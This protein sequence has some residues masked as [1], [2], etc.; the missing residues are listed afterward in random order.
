MTAT[1]EAERRA[2][3]VIRRWADQIAAARR[4]GDHLR[5]SQY[6]CWLFGAEVVL[7]LAGFNELALMA[8][9][10]QDVET[11]D[12]QAFLLGDRQDAA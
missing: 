8:Q 5:A 7:A 12:L 4:D 6:E 9:R 2:A 10:S 11:H 3:E 1:T